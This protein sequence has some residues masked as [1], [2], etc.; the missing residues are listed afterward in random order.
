M[1]A[2]KLVGIVLGVIVLSIVALVIWASAA[3]SR[4]FA[5]MQE[6]SKAHLA[7][8]K[9]ADM[10]RPVLRGMA[11]AGN[12]WDDY[13]LAQAE[14]KKFAKRTKLG[15]IVERSPKADPEVA[16]EAL[17]AHGSAIDLLRRGAGRATSRYP[18]EWEKGMN[19]PMPGFLDTQA[20]ANLAALRARALVEEGKAREAVGL[21]LDVCQYGRDL[22]GDGLMISYMIGMAILNTG[23]REARDQFVS[24]KLDKAALEDLAAGLETLDGSLP[25]YDKILMNEA[26]L[27]G[28]M[29]DESVV[30]TWGPQRMIYADAVER[31]SDAM[32]AAGKA[33]S[34]PW[35]D[36][37]KELQR[38]EAEAQKGWNPLAQM[39]IPAMG[40]SNQVGRGRRAQ[41][42]ALRMAVASALG[43]ALDLDDPFGAKMRKEDLDGNLRFW[44]VGADGVDD[45]GVGDWKHDSKD[46]VVELKK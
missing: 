24:G 7:E 1:K 9:A 28:G 21:L 26:L 35:A 44:S 38:I 3:G 5:R 4:K 12:A 40:K 2:W 16:K 20:T 18:Y 8:V 29:L 23:L 30:G 45:G 19:M 22:G 10:R 15:E 6:R 17:A 32:A 33:E 27:F 42:R 14:L 34:M 25:R 11:E 36:A 39:A 37:Q 41:L 46:I 43:K 13:F 31:T